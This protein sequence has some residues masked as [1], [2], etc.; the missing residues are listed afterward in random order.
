MKKTR[1]DSGPSAIKRRGEKKKRFNFTSKCSALASKSCSWVRTMRE[2][3]METR[4]EIS[5]CKDHG[6][7]GGGLLLSVKKWD[8]TL[9]GEEAG[10]LHLGIDWGFKWGVYNCRRQREH[11]VVPRLRAFRLLL[12]GS[13]VTV[14]SSQGIGEERREK[15]RAQ[16]RARGVMVSLTREEEG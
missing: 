10:E 12:P 7:Q 8:I 14:I 16:W 15:S 5:S 13:A 1:Q 9:W 2:N 11:R 6:R 3:Q 4:V